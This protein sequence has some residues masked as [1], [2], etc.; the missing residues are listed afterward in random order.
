MS[1]LLQRLTE[2]LAAPSTMDLA[3]AIPL[4]VLAGAS[5]ATIAAVIGMP[6]FTTSGLGVIL[7]G[8]AVNVTSA[9]IDNILNATSDRERRKL[10]QQGLQAGD[11]QVQ[12]LVAGAMVYAGPDVA[13]A[14]P[15]A[16]RTDLVAALEQGMR[17]AGGPLA[18]IA[19]RYA[20]AL[21]A[22]N[23]DWA[24][25]QGTLGR[26]LA[27]LT[28]EAVAEETISDFH[29]K[30]HTVEGT[31]RQGQQAK[32]IT[33]GSQVAT[34]VR[35]PRD[36]APPAPS[37]SAPQPT[38]PPEDRA[39]LPATLSAD[40]V[41]FSYGHALI[42]GVGAYQHPS[43]RA[44]GTVTNDARA[45]AALLR[46][47]QRAAYP[48]DQVTV[49]RDTTATKARILAELEA[50]AQRLAG[51]PGGTALICFAGHGEPVAGS[52]AL[53]PY[54]ADPQQLAATA[55]TAEAFH[56]A[57]ATIRTHAKRLVVLLN[58]CHAG[59]VGDEVLEAGT[60]SLAD[61]A[62]PP[63]FY[64]PLA[65]G[66]GQVVISS[67][68]P[69]QKSGA[70]SQ[71][72]SQHTTFGAHLLSA[73]EG[74]ASGQGPGIGVFELFTHLRASVPADARSIVYRNAPLVQEPLFYASQLDD[75]VAVALRPAVAPGTL[76]TDDDLA[77][78]L[79]AL[80]LQ[81]EAQGDAVSAAL[82]RERDTLLDRI[83]GV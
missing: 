44:V 41:H 55:I 8:L 69:E 19:P 45:L 47:P 24:A 21:C 27:T 22:P 13:G 68:R 62:P 7:G 72:R 74:A 48:D 82:L 64:R 12:T 43:L 40:G 65:V 71:H 78:R 17:E 83:G 4:G 52:Y 75:N 26:E 25:L 5:A 66:S 81:V 10:I 36:P 2:Y 20:A 32:N 37:A 35:K 33:G 3:E 79:V 57:I 67:S 49:L 50:L 9:L 42:I 1:T 29:Q 53:L 11:P 15:L 73:L 39:P 63:E 61:A 60:E 70:R 59:G 18:A 80:E 51:A 23:A 6:A 58:C 56:R 16:D 14:L 77:A 38:P 31:V 34:G 54:D 30:A 28:Q 46:D 76:G